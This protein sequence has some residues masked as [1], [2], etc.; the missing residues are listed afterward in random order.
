MKIT[1]VFETYWITGGK[2]SL[3]PFGSRFQALFE[4]KKLNVKQE[5]QNGNS[6]LW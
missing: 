3:G 1:Y 6:I 5:K 2:S 4:M